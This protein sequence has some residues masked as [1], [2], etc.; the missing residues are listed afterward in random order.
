MESEEKKAIT[1]PAETDALVCLLLSALTVALV[2]KPLADC[3]MDGWWWG[4]FIL[5]NG[6][7]IIHGMKKGWAKGDPANGLVIVAGPIAFYF[8][9]YLHV[10]RK[11]G[12]RKK[13][14]VK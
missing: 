9:T 5:F 6:W 7:Y 10:W 11:Y 14:N 13:T 3:G 4:F 8:W 2:V 1:Y 12:R